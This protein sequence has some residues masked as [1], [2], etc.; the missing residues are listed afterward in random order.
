MGGSETARPAGPRA[1]DDRR[2]SV[3]NRW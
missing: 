2:A 1:R 3:L